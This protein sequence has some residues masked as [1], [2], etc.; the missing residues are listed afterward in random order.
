MPFC[1]SSN[2]HLHLHLHSA[3]GLQLL[4][5]THTKAKAL[6]QNQSFILPL[7]LVVSRLFLIP[8]L[9]TKA[10]VTTSCCWHTFSTLDASLSSKLLNQA[11]MSFLGAFGDGLSVGPGSSHHRRSSSRSRPKRT[12]SRSRSRTRGTGNS[13]VDGLFGESSSSHRKEDASRAFF[14]LGNSSRSSFF[15]FGKLNSHPLL[16]IHAT[17]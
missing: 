10:I 1:D 14:G 6:L 7:L 16:T 8:T 9:D 12:R 17:D 2:L 11:R 4:D 5:S 3:P 13:F 15:G